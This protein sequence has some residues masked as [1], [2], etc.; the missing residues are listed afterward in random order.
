MTYVAKVYDVSKRPSKEVYSDEGTNNFDGLCKL[1]KF[2]NNN[3]LEAGSCLMFKKHEGLI[4]MYKGDFHELKERLNVKPT[5]LGG[6]MRSYKMK[7]LDWVVLSE[8]Q[9]ELLKKL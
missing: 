2:V 1:F 5:E 6:G 8:E 4:L 3:D 9:L 7:N